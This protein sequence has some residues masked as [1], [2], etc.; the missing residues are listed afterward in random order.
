M[1]NE[2]YKVMDSVL[3]KDILSVIEENNNQMLWMQKKIEKDFEKE[4]ESKKIINNY[5]ILSKSIFGKIFVL[6]ILRQKIL[7]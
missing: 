6:P 2:D 5:S 7:K 4:V 1:E 3:E